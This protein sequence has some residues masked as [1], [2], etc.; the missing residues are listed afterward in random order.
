MRTRGPGIPKKEEGIL[1]R[2]TDQGSEPTE[3]EVWGVGPRRDGKAQEKPALL[4]CPHCWPWPWAQR[5]WQLRETTGLE[6]PYKGIL[7]GRTQ[8][9]SRSQ[10]DT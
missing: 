6:V 3:K 7:T 4:T 2:K 10:V 9:L 1:R 5:M 8:G